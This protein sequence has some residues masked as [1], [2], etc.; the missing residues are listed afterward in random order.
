MNYVS[1][2]CMNQFTKGQIDRMFYIWSIYRMGNES[3][4]TGYQLFEF[5]ILTDRWPNQ[6]HLSLTSTDGKF[7]WD[8]RKDEYAQYY[9]ANKLIKEDFCI[10]ATKNYVFTIYDDNNDGIRKPGYYAIRYNGMTLE[11]NSSFGANES[12]PFVGELRTSFNMSCFSIN[13]SV[14][15]QNKGWVG[16]LDVK[17]GDKVLVSRGNYEEVYTFGHRNVVESAEFL[18]IHSND[19][20]APIEISPDHLILKDSKHWV[21]AGTVQV[22]D[23]LTKGDGSPVVI[24]LVRY[25]TRKGLFAPFTKSGSIVVNDIVASNYVAFQGSE[26]LIIGG[27]ETPLSFHWLAHTFE[28]GHRLACNL[29]AC[30]KE[31]Y[32]DTGISHWVFLPRKAAEMLLN[33]YPLVTVLVVFPLILIFGALSLVEQWSAAWAVIML[34]VLVLALTSRSSRLMLETRKVL[35]HC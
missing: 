9:P 34:A 2:T 17:I 35:R 15:L 33:Q 22:G 13:S 6:I 30:N 12:T 7:R 4:S 31:T 20:N 27:V 8:T 16:I 23:V 10:D 29:I 28:S 26:Y 25:V 3:C 32:S 14:N 11:R 5:E 18:Q 19:T 21:P 1:E 24:T